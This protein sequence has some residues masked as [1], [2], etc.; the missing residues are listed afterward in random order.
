VS[1]YAANHPTKR[2]RSAGSIVRGIY[3]SS[4]VSGPA[5]TSN[6]VCRKQRQRG[7]TVAYERC[8]P[9]LTELQASVWAAVVNARPKVVVPD[10]G[11]GE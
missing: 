3:A 1:M 6:S 7:H 9:A 4:G 2:A 8:V 10:G 5:A 11:G